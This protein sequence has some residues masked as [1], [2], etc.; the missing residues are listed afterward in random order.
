MILRG[1]GHTLESIMR[2]SPAYRVKALK[3]V[4]KGQKLKVN[5]L[6]PV[7]GQDITQGVM[8]AIPKVGA[9]A[10]AGLLGNVILD[11]M[12]DKSEEER[13]FTIETNELLGYPNRPEALTEGDFTSAEDFDKY[14]LKINNNRN[15]IW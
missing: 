7:P 6:R 13:Q 3:A 4:N 9:A 2:M 5:N 14:M 10:G 1:A 8:R 12:E 15:S 11:N